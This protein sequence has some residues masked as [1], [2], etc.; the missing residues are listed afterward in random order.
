[1]DS[2]GQGNYLKIMSFSLRLTLVDKAL[3][4]HFIDMVILD[5]LRHFLIEV[6]GLPWSLILDHNLYKSDFYM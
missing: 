4:E 2:E 1:M 6:S 3:Q 5:A